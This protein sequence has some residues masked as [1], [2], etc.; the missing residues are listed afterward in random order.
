[1]IVAPT[2]ALQQD[3]QDIC[4]ALTNFQTVARDDQLRGVRVI[5]A[6][7]GFGIDGVTFLANPPDDSATALGVAPTKALQQDR[8]DLCDALANFQTVDFELAP[9]QAQSC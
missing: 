5:A 2:K 7:F 9:D 8:Q 1:M 4:D 6:Y 3:K